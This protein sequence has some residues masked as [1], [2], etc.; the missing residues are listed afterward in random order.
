MSSQRVIAT[1]AALA[2][3]STPVSAQNAGARHGSVGAA[4][5]GGLLGTYSGLF[6]G[7]IADDLTSPNTDSHFIIVGI[8]AVGLAAGTYAGATDRD[9][10]IH[11]YRGA[12]I[13]AAAG[14]LLFELLERAKVTSTDTGPRWFEGALYGAAVGALIGFVLPTSESPPSPTAHVVYISV[15]WSF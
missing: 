6:L 15:G 2:A 9:R 3:L 12:G 10:V 11:G 8:A 7:D 13:G 14:A 5:A 4:I 1:L